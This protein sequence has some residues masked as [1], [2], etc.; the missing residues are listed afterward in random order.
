MWDMEHGLGSHYEEEQFYDDPM[1]RG[2]LDEDSWTSAGTYPYYEDEQGQAHYIERS[3]EPL[4]HSEGYYYGAPLHRFFHDEVSQSCW[5]K[6]YGRTAGEPLSS[7][8]ADH[9][10]DGALCYPHCQE[11]YSGV[12]PI[13]W[14]NCP[15]ETGFRDDGAYCYKP[16][17]YGRGAGQVHQC[18]GCE[19]WGSLW[20][21][22]CHEHFHN[23]GCCVCS[24]D[25]PKKM[26]D[27]GISCAK[28]SYS[29][30][31]GTP[32]VC[33]AEQEQSGA[34]CYTPCEHNADGVG[35]VCWGKCPAGTKE[36]GALCL[37]QDEIC[38][39]YIASEVKLAF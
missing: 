22:T 36:C 8:P 1:Q 16:D 2:G 18:Q 3:D 20:Y 29:R 39:E 14:Q 37:G 28:D 26:T 21:P 11:G 10:K 24:P 30:T 34:L 7:C 25:C 19:K 35:P 38:S 23:V 4:T 27:I 13:C 32:L 33:H 6:A 15:A 9:E 31:A 12:G 5:K 17:A